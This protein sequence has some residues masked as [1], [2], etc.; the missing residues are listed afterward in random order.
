MELKQV[1]DGLGAKQ[2]TLARVSGVSRFKINQA[3][4]GDAVFSPQEEVAL[5]AAL[6]QVAEERKAAIR[7]L[8]QVANA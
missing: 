3:L 6:K 4:F 5:V 7:V 1:I 2:T 8:E